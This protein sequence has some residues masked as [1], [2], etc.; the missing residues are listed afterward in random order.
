MEK[1]QIHH[2]FTSLLC[3]SVLEYFCLEREKNWFVINSDYVFHTFGAMER[4][5]IVQDWGYNEWFSSH[6]SLSHF[7]EWSYESLKQKISI[8]YWLA[9]KQAIE[10]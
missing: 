2:K 4:K 3:K 1:N 8:V 5:E 9:K 10:R 7:P 6:N